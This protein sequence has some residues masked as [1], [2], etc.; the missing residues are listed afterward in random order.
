MAN[1]PSLLILS[2]A[3]VPLSFFKVMLA[4]AG[5]LSATVTVGVLL[6]ATPPAVMALTV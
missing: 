3:S 1:V 5:L 2:L 4:E 6:A